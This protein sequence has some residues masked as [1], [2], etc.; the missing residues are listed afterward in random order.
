MVLIN[1]LRNSG[2]LGKL[3]PFRVSSFLIQDFT[4]TLQLDLI[5]MVPCIDA[6]YQSYEHLEVNFE[7]NCKDDTRTLASL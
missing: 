4:N 2:T 3:G 5:S 7:I 1:S 6:T